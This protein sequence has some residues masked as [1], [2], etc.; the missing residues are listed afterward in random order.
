MAV[1]SSRSSV[2]LIFLSAIC[3]LI[4]PAIAGPTLLRYS[5]S[6]R[7]GGKYSSISGSGYKAN[8]N[9]LFSSLSS[10]STE[11]DYGFYNSSYG[12]K[13]HEVYAIALCRGDLKPDECRNCLNISK[14]YLTLERCPNEKEAIVWYDEC[15]LRYSSR[16]IFSSMEETPE[17]FI[18][19]I[20]NI[21]AGDAKFE[22]NKDLWNLLQNL[23]D[24]AATGGSLRKFATGKVAAGPNFQTM[25]ALVQCTPDLSEQDCSYCLRR[26]FENFWRSY[27]GAIGGRVL[28]P[29]CNF[30]FENFDFYHRTADAPSPLPPPVSAP[31]P[32]LAPQGTSCVVMLEIKHI[33]LCDY[34]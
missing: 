1:I 32:S 23:R 33:K 8:L 15:M 3:I 6:D 29:S 12:E 5:C 18:V 16:S 24:G 22:F 7:Q 14:D 11:I 10:N 30:R 28:R 26:A 17:F 25:N 21:S 27:A 34:M 31:S 9:H 19:S 13:P 4:A 20:Y 2:L